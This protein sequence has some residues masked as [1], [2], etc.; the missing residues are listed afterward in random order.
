[1]D[2]NTVE[3]MDKYHMQKSHLKLKKNTPG[4]ML[5]QRAYDGWEKE[6]KKQAEVKT[7]Y[8]HWNTQA[9]AMYVY[10]ETTH[11]LLG[12]WCRVH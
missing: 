3:I 12:D 6:I 11:Q 4:K 9:Y 10:V 5:K 1:M 7:K 8:S 2:G